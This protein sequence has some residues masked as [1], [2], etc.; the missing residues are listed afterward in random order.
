MEKLQQALQKARQNRDGAGTGRSTYVSRGPA[1]SSAVDAMWDDLKGHEP[2]RK[3]LIKNRIVTYESGRA[4]IPFDVLRTKIVLQ[5]RKN[6]WRRLAITSPTAGC[7]KTTLAC[8]LALGLS[9]QSDIRT[10]LVELDLRRPSMA[11]M[12]AAEP[13]RDVTEMLLNQS[14][15]Q[16]QALRFRQNVAISMA[17][18]RASDPMKFLLSQEMTDTLKRLESQYRPDI[19]MFDLP[20]MLVGDDTRAFLSNVDCALIVACAEKTKI[21]EIDA[22]EREIAENTNVVGIVLNQNRFP[23]EDA[24]YDYGTS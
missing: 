4:A 10:I 23:D 20:P 12:L 15:F 9:R 6:G 24:V 2:N 7:G 14:S 1:S 18:Q 11:R 19:S 5:M 16:D 8:N 22:C 3:V 17:R 13:A 21:R